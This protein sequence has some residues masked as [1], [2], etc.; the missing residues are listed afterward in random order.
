MG[1]S[2]PAS[3]RN[4][5]PNLAS[6]YAILTVIGNIIHVSVS[7]AAILMAALATWWGMPPRRRVYLW[8]LVALVA[9]CDWYLTDVMKM[10]M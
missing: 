10:R 7:V 3:A 8:A 4:R 9:A 2:R 6:A 1:T 5:H